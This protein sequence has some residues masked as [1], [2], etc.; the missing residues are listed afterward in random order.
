MFGSI[1]M[2]VDDLDIALSGQI[3]RR[4]KRAVITVYGRIKV[5]KEEFRD[6]YNESLQRDVERCVRDYYGMHADDMD[7]PCD[8]DE[9]YGVYRK[10][11]GC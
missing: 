8:A 2:C 5:S 3:A 10:Y 1:R 4:M 6:V 7:I 11:Y 9:W